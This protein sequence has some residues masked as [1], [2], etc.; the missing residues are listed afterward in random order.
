P[1]ELAFAV[2]LT[3]ASAALLY[4]AY[5]IAGFR[6]LSSP[7]AIP[8][9]TTAAMLVTAALVV[10]RT[11]RL[12]RTEDETLRIAVF[13]AMVVLMVLLLVLYGIALRPLGF[14]PTSAI[15]LFVAIKLLSGRSIAFTLTV[16]LAC[17]AVIWLIF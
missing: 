5:D 11:A 10:W 4:N 13:P 16:T 1:G 15:F 6:A 7:G 17:V 12:P 8:M 2:F 14:V 9:A 3:L